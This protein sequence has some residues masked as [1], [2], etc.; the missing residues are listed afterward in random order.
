VIDVK[1]VYSQTTF[2]FIL[3]QRSA[4]M[5]RWKCESQCFSGKSPT[6]KKIKSTMPESLSTYLCHLEMQWIIGLRPCAQVPQFHGLPVGWW[7][8]LGQT[9]SSD[10]VFVLHGVAAFPTLSHVKRRYIESRAAAS[11]QPTTPT[12]AWEPNEH[13]VYHDKI[14]PKDTP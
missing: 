7:S 9:H 2:I 8:W 1:C 11:L 3:L 13:H 6:Q 10:P 12:D 14:P 4:L 5:W